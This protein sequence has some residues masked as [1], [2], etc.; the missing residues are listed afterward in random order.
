MSLLNFDSSGHTSKGEKKS[1]KLLFGIG[2]LV[3]TIALGST[4]AASINLNGGGPVEFGQG[5]VQTT[6]C[7][8]EITLTPYSTFVNADGAGSYKFSSLKVSGIDSSSD[9]C[10]GKTFVIKAY[11]D[12]GILNLVSY[13]DTAN[14]EDD[15]SYNYVEISNNG[16]EFTWISGGSD[17]DDVI[18]GPD[19]YITETSFTLSFT[20]DLGT[21]TRTPLASAEEVKRITIESKDSTT[22]IPSAWNEI[23]WNSE[24]SAGPFVFA[25]SLTNGK[26]DWLYDADISE[27]SFSYGFSSNGMGIGGNNGPGFPYVTNFDISSTAK[28]TIQFHFKY[29]STDYDSGEDE[30]CPDH[31][32]VIFP[33]GTIPSWSWGE[34]Y[35]SGLMARW[36]CGRPEVVGTTGESESGVRLSVGTAYIGVLTYDPNVS[37]DQLVLTTK[38]L[39]GTVISLVSLSEGLTPGTGYRI[40]FSADR[41]S[42]AGYSYFKNLIITIEPAT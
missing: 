24:D 5:V 14:P 12:S 16:G 3:G 42:P 15:G 10:S 7:D 41:D 32:V 31:G 29:D 37:T 25:D 21:I 18:P 8:D 40:G 22:I 9:K 34:T 26:P 17:G 27:S 11:G 28:V 35:S 1:L 19:G 23:S 4:L 30:A 38:E 36:N 6:A 13:A 20:S 33:T 2:A 39:D